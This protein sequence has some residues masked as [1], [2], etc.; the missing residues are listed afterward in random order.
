MAGLSDYVS[1]HGEFMVDLVPEHVPATKNA[2]KPVAHDEPTYKRPEAESVRAT[3]SPATVE[4]DVNYD[5]VRQAENSIKKG[6]V[7]ASGKWYPYEGG[8]G[9]GEYDIGYSH[10]IVDGKVK[11][12][13]KQYDAAQ[14]FTQS[15]INQLFREDMAGA[16]REAR[17]Y[18]RLNRNQQQALASIF[19]Q[20]GTNMASYGPKALA[21]L[22]AYEKKGMQDDLDTFIYEAFDPNQGIAVKVKKGDKPLKSLQK[23]VAKRRARFMGLPK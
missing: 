23:R 8:L 17:K 5:F 3:P 20:S 21:A 14:G 4:E 18:K 9:Y 13:G 16:D 1:E 19:Y 11:I 22:K 10:K 12:G 6:Y 7:S 15:Q 2:K